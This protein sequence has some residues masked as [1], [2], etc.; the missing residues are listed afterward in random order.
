MNLLETVPLDEKG[1]WPPVDPKEQ[2]VLISLNAA[3]V[4]VGGYAVWRRNR[5]WFA[6][7]LAAFATWGFL[8]KY[9]I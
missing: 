6:L 1:E 9:L 7:W 3:S 8:S 2:T 4:G 5:W